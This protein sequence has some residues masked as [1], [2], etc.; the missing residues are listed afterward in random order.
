[1]DRNRFRVGFRRLSDDV[2]PTPAMEVDFGSGLRWSTSGRT[3]STGR[4]RREMRTRLPS[5]SAGV[6][7]SSNLLPS[8]LSLIAAMAVNPLAPVTAAH[9]RD[10]GISCVSPREIQT[11]RPAEPRS[12]NV[13]FQHDS[14]PTRITPPL[15]RAS[16]TQPARSRRL[17]RPGRS[18]LAST[19]NKH[20]LR[21]RRNDRRSAGT[22][23]RVG[24]P[25]RHFQTRSA[26]TARG[27]RP[28]SHR[29][30]RRQTACRR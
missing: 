8:L 11:R 23:R 9:R 29:H 12:W 14:G 3:L 26:A 6:A 25:G 22:S 10:G 21:R 17:A 24:I 30:P 7:L 19:R 4:R 13:G 1:M 15:D 16:P 27:S 18:P 28:G 20:H 5:V 2:S